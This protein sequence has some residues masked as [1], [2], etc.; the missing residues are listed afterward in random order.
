[1][2]LTRLLL[3]SVAALSCNSVCLAQATQIGPDT[4]QMFRNQP[5]GEAQAQAQRLA[6]LEAAD[7]DFY[8]AIAK[9]VN[10]EWDDMT[11]GIRE[12]WIEYGEALELVEEQYEARMGLLEVL[13]SGKYL[14]DLNPA[15][16]SSTISNNYLPFPI[17]VTMVYEVMTSDGLERVE[18]TALDET[19]M[20]EDIECRAVLD[21]AYLEG[22]L[23]EKTYDWY[24]QHLD[25]SVWYMG[26]ISFNYD[27]EGF[28]ED[29]DG[30]WRTG[31][32]G[33]QPGY[34]VKAN[35]VVGDVYRQEFLIGE[36]EDIGAV[37]SLNE[38]VTVPYGTFT[39]CLMTED[40]TPIEPDVREFKYYAPGV[41]VVL[42]YDPESGERLE[43]IDILP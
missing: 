38:T 33:A 1:M 31:V 30:S 9:A 35:P 4:Q 7:A 14:P 42:E 11:D 18:V 20:I 17:G 32:D 22:D 40:G 5:A 8:A 10:E 3:F 37:R 27:E 39:N 19:V 2:T 23:I 34:I 12:A 15:E 6:D 25:G 21:V 43:L 36:A 26:E 16:F 29:I 24:A 13:G 41:G 28:L